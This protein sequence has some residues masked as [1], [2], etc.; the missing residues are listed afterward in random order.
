MKRRF[1]PT[2]LYLLIA[3]VLL[4]IMNATL[5]FFLT[6]GSSKA[7][8]S[9]IRGRMLDISNTAAAMI[10]GD[11]LAKV[12]AGD[13]D[14][15][16]YMK[17]MET[18]TYY[19]DN[20]DLEYI[21]CIRDMG[22]GEFI[23]TIDPT[24]ED[25]GEFGESIVYT[26]ALYNASLGRASVDEVPYEDAWG[27]FYS[28]YSPVFDSNG[29]VAGIVAVDFDADW[30][31]RQI[32]DQMRTIFIITSIS[33]IFGIVIVFTVITRARKRIKALYGELNNLS[34]GIEELANVLTDGAH[35]EG[36]ELLYDDSEKDDNSY[37]E[38]N[39]IGNRIRSLQ[40]YMKV[41]VYY[42]RSK[43]YKDGLT[44]LENRMA[45]L[46]YVNKL[47]EKIRNGE[48]GKFVVGMF[49][50]NGLKDINDT[51][52]HESGDSTIRAASVIL[53]SSFKGARIFRIGGDE[54]VVIFESEE[55]DTR[56]LF[57]ECELAISGEDNGDGE[58]PILSGG[59]ARFDVT[60]DHCFEDTF[61]RADGRMYE[62]KKE[63]HRRFGSE[64]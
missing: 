62:N 2:T 54:F 33:L 12:Q 19:Q 42:V 17:I 36:T 59:Y 15:P 22:E 61:K 14:T 29:D 37:D 34:E 9:L 26:D 32:S 39:A 53:Q 44:G 47:D 1:N 18:L 13:K 10:D 55:S 7:M 11:V 57:N 24:T 21:Y 40:E 43:A 41:Q 52:G 46:E 16:E 35:L 38:V 3:A 49:D 8:K 60:T 25:P 20:I 58:N 45:Y 23:F 50:I 28:A 4:L 27:R 31:D 30:Y 56:K 63:F 48:A 6:R 5:G 51:R 64:R